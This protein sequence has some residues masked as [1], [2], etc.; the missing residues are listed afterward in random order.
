MFKSYNYK[1]ALTRASITIQII[2][3]TTLYK[4]S[5]FSTN[6]NIFNINDTTS[7]ISVV[8][9]KGLEDITDTFTDIVWSRF[10]VNAG[11]YEEDLE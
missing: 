1:D 6:G 8:V 9:R 10:H 7:D 5:I 4:A 2:D 11:K 3:D